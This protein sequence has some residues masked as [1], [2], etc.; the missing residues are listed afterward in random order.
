[1][2]HRPHVRGAACA[3]A[4]VMG[5]V[6][7]AGSIDRA[8][9][10]ALELRDRLAP[11]F[12]SRDA[13]FETTFELKNWGHATAAPADL[14]GG[15]VYGRSVFHLW[16]KPE[17][18]QLQGQHTPFDQP[19]A[20]LSPVRT[21][22]WRDG[23]AHVRVAPTALG[24]AW[25]TSNK[26]ESLF[27]HGQV[28]TFNG[29]DV[30]HPTGSTLFGSLDALMVTGRTVDGN[31]TVDQVQRPGVPR[32]QSVLTVAVE[33]QGDRDVPIWHALD[34]KTIDGPY[35]SF[36]CEYFDWRTVDGL[37]LPWG[38]RRSSWSSDDGGDPLIH[39]APSRYMLASAA[40]QS[41][42]TTI[43]RQTL[44]RR[45][46]AEYDAAAVPM[47]P[48]AGEAVW[49]EDLG[50]ALWVGDPEVNLDGVIWRVAESPTGVPPES[51]AD[52]MHGAVEVGPAEGLAH[53][54]D[55][56]DSPARRDGRGLLWGI[57]VYVGIIAAGTVL[58][59]AV[60][61]KIRADARARA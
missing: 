33:R 26:L 30:H 58:G 21:V 24:P 50:L 34:I 48:G 40:D 60:V 1:M 28:W 36:L 29:T 10:P 59:V 46:P 16:V 43:E 38:A 44:S 7:T 14:H 39:L 32:E 22:A 35:R 19:E 51:L 13:C 12:P 42:C 8:T 5:G 25:I 11:S 55:L 31:T 4:M 53:A 20:E 41:Y 52:F 17:A 45:S 3:I 2:M 15:S 54:G 6:S 47:T 9:G 57:L 49:H 18:V 27:G 37:T 61:R 56:P 23:R